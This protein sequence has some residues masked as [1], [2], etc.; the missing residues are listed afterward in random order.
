MENKTSAREFVLLGLTSDPHLQSFLCFVFSVIYFITLFGNMVI[1]I[2]IRT[3]AHLH[4]PM[5]FFLF[6]LALADICYA[7]TVVPY[8]LVNFL[9]K[10]KTIEFS[11]CII[12]M[13]L[14]L[15]S[16]GSEI[17]MLSAMAYDRYVAICKPLHYQEVMNKLVCSQLVGG[18]WAMGVL[19]SIVNTLPMLNVQFCEYTEI[20][21]FSYQ[22]SS[23]Q[24]SILTPMLNPIIYSLKNNDVKTALGRIIDMI[25]VAACKQAYS[26]MPNSISREQY[27]KPR[28][29]KMHKLWVMSLTVAAVSF[30]SVCFLVLNDR[31]NEV[32][33]LRHVKLMQNCCWKFNATALAQYRAELGL[34]CNAS[35][36]LAVTQDNTPLG[37]EIVY[38]GYRSKSL[39][40]SSGLLEILPEKSPFQDPVYKTCAVVGNGGILRNSSCGSKIDG[41]QFVIRFHGLNGQR[42]PF[43]K[44][45]ASYGKT[46]FLIPAF[47]YP[48]N[49]FML[50]NAAL[51]LCQ[52]I[53]L[54]GFWP[55]SLHPDG[56]SLP[57]HYYDNV[58]P[59][60]GIHTMPK[61]FTYYVD[62]HFH[63][64][65]RLH[66]G[67]C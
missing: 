46:W 21:H 53:T 62:L 26:K 2:V 1:M 44:A 67:Q 50:V 48:G 32:W 4:S 43:V 47:S 10:Q 49:S 13:S 30:V 15:L 38:D 39:K 18:A 63:G 59:K 6:H 42:L 17:F 61:E 12:Q 58:L 20:K 36:W 56:H 52:H 14:I 7:T 22:L 33:S 3:D 60:R 66:L 31:V 64:V 28:L 29:L 35:A 57:H 9:L 23:I 24:Y 65:L 54:Y 8:M 34:C 41:H 45:A 16:A 5:Y 37:S 19:H 55:F 51:E 40:V 27:V 11:A 25:G